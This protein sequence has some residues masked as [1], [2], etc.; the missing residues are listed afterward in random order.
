[1]TKSRLFIAI[2]DDEECVRKALSRL[3]RSAGID[4]EAFPSGEDFLESLR[5][6]QPDC[7]LLD[8]H[9]P[10]LSGFEVQTRLR[11]S[12]ARLPVIIITCQDS[13]AA[14]ERAFA[15]GAVDYLRKPVRSRT[16][17]DAIHRAVREEDSSGTL[18]ERP[19]QSGSP[20]S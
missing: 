15:G 6:R 12:G 10:R 11:E 17:L 8:L 9:M 5:A 19:E 18:E 1:V 4:A 13:P 3:L 2:V 20:G 14:H 7:V 16:L